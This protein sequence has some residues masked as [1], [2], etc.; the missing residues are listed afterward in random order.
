MPEIVDNV[1]VGQF[2]KDQLK[3]QKISQDALAQKLN[4]TKSA[5]SQN[6][7]GKSS[8]SRK[9]L[10][11]ISE[12][13]NMKIEDILSCKRSDN[14]EYASEFQKLARRGLNEFKR[15]YAKDIVNIVISAN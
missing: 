6:L 9:N 14:D 12:L 2:L 13:L 1:K 3:E 4:I 15:N 10:E 5:V 8:F 7:N 11:V